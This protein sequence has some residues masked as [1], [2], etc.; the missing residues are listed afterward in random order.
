MDQK[1]DSRPPGGAASSRGA[2]CSPTE[3]ARRSEGLNHAEELHVL[4][5]RYVRWP[6]LHQ[7]LG[8]S[9][10]TVWRLEQAGLFPR[11]VRL[12]KNAVGWAESAVEAWLRERPS[13]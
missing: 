11:R 8:L 6:E 12:S 4:R 7:R 9:K 1:E 2:S 3:T 10:S 13:V 5:T